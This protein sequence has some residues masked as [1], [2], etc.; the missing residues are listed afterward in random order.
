[1][2]QFGEIISTISIVIASV[3]VI[4]A[5]IYYFFYIR[6][7]RK[8]RQ[9]D[10]IMRLATFPLTKEFLDADTQVLNLDYKDYD[11]FVKQYGPFSSRKPIHL[12]IRQIINYF[13]ILGVLAEE[14]L[15]DASF[16]F[17]FIAIDARWKRVEPIVQEFANDLKLEW[18]ENLYNLEKKQK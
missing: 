5:V 17:K 14:K 16:I 2:M 7:L 12:A 3:G 9:T 18:F 10:L 15:I 11:D 1:M 8:V 4:V 13:E 6:Y